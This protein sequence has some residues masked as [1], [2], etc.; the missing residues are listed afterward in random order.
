M[1]YL[2]EM[3]VFLETGVETDSLGAGMQT[4]HVREERAQNGIAA[5]AIAEVEAGAGAKA[6]LSPFDLCS[7]ISPEISA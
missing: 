5:G 4:P 3:K 6:D 1:N 7:P 2:V